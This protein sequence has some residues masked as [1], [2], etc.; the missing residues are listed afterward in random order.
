MD[1]IETTSKTKK[2]SEK[3]KADPFLAPVNVRAPEVDLD[4]KETPGNKEWPAGARNYPW[5][6]YPFEFS[7]SKFFGVLLGVTLIGVV[8]VKFVVP[9]LQSRL[10]LGGGILPLAL[11]PAAPSGTAPTDLKKDLTD[12]LLQ[13]IQENT[14]SNRELAEAIIA[15][16]KSNTDNVTKLIQALESPKPEAGDQ[17]SEEGFSL[18]DEKATILKLSGIDLDDPIVDKSVFSKVK[19]R[20]TLD[21]LIDSFDRIVQNRKSPEVSRFLA[22]N[23]EKGKSL[24]QE[25]RKELR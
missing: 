3:K 19:N 23:A 7:Y 5:P 22:E 2:S 13:A 15:G 1:P 16:N 21:S 24:A 20:K 11:S 25:Y 14:K 8:L 17:R 12:P 10:G 4:E 6:N 9:P 18:E